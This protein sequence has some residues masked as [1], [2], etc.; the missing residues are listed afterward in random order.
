MK[1]KNSAVEIF[2]QIQTRIFGNTAAPSVTAL[3]GEYGTPFHVLIST[4]I[5][6]R[7]R[8]QV[9]YDASKRLFS[10]AD[11][12]E[13][14]A[15]EHEQTI[16]SLI[17]PCGFYSTKAKRIIE[18]SRILLE[19]HGGKV[20][21]K[22]E[23]LLLLPGVGRKTANLTLGLG[24]G[25]PAICVD[26]HVHR[27]SNRLGWAKTKVPDETE[28]V[29]EKLFPQRYWIPLNEVLVRFGQS[30]CLPRTP[31]C[32]SCPVYEICPRTGVKQ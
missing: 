29:L 1:R 24:F 30:I 12:P 15:L 22:L 25:I 19:T 13:L 17:Y 27:I 9:T 31:R 21:S 28:K 20:P 7:T 11:T 32:L 14:L 5:S 2:T 4:L 3:A 8:D 6:L 23:D 16:A 10:H 26:I 18:I